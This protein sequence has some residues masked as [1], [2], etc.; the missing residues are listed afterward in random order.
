MEDTNW[1]RILWRDNPKGAMKEYRLT[2]VTCMGPHVHHIFLSHSNLDSNLHLMK[3]KRYPL[4]SFATLHH[5]YVDDLPSGAK[6]TEKKA[7]EPLFHIRTEV[8]S[9]REVLSEIA[10]VFDPLGLLSLCVVFMKIL[11]TRAMEIKS[12]MGRTNPKDFGAKT[13]GSLPKGTSSYR[14]NENTEVCLATFIST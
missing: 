4:V 11:F 7:V 9:K 6:V 12:R 2:T 14:K 5:F 8:Y 10:R 3:G 13:V 1:Q